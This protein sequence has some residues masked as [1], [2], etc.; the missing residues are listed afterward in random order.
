MLFCCF[1]HRYIF[2]KISRSVPRYS[3]AVPRYTA[4][5]SR[6]IVTALINRNKLE[7]VITV[8]YHCHYIFSSEIGRHLTAISSGR[9]SLIRWALESPAIRFTF[10]LSW[11]PEKIK[12]KCFLTQHCILFKRACVINLLRQVLTTQILP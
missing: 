3:V 5:R 2:C 12:G 1:L 11:A 4:V 8:L 7:T 6:R 9:I 10:L